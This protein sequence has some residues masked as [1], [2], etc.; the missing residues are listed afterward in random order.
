[1]QENVDHHYLTSFLLF[2]LFA[3]FFRFK[4][5]YEDHC[6]ALTADHTLKFRF[7]AKIM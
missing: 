6:Q 4:K 3:G 7:T 2:S 1:L 5:G